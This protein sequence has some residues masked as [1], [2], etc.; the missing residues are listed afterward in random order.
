[1]HRVKEW[2]ASGSQLTASNPPCC[3][4]H[5]SLQKSA[6][7]WFPW[8]IQQA[9]S[10]ILTWNSWVPL[11]TRQ[12]SP[13]ATPLPKP[14]TPCSMTTQQ[15]SIGYAEGLSPPPKL[16]PTSYASKPYMATTTAT[17]PHM[18]TSRV[19]LTAWLMTAQGCGTCLMMPYSPTSTLDTHRPVAGHFASYPVQ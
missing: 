14:Q 4:A 1:M 12:C 17:L 5:P 11:P 8:Q 16:P 2:E 13:L 9:A 3:G 10:P 7:N 18:T 15:Q 19:Q 6:N